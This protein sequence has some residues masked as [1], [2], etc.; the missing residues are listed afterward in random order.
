MSRR[1]G[2][3]RDLAAHLV[4][5]ELVV[6]PVRHHSPACAAQVERVVR[7]RRPSVVL[8]EGPRGFDPLVPLLARPD[9]VMPLAVYTWLDARATD[10]RVAAYYPFCDYSPELVAIRE[11]TAAGTPVRFIDLELGEQQHSAGT[12]PPESL[13]QET[14]YRHSEGLRLLAERLGCRDHEDLWERLFESRSVPLEEYVAQVAAYCLLARDDHTPE[15]LAADGTLAREAEM[16]HHV[17]EALAARLPGDGPV[18]VVLG[19][20]HAVALPDLLATPPSRPEL[21]APPAQSALIRYTF[22]RLEQLNGYA[23]GMTS[24]AWHQLLWEHRDRAGGEHPRVQATLLALQRVVAELRGPL[25]MPVPHPL[26]AAA[27]AHA[28]QLAHLRDREAP[29]RSDLLDAITSC[30]VQGDVDVEGRIVLTAAH[31]VLTGDRIG[32]VPAGAGRPPLVVDTLRR[33]RAQRLR[34][35]ELDRSSVA[36]DLYRREAHRTTSRLLHGLGLL[37]IPFAFRAAGPDFVS[38]TGLGRL[39]ERWDYQWSPATEGALAEASVLGSTLPEAVARRF[40]QL[41]A[42]FEEAAA[43]S[44]PAA[45]GLLTQ[46][47]TVGLHDRLDQVVRLVREAVTADAAFDGVVTAVS[48]LA[49]LAEAREPLGARE[50]AELPAL[51]QL[52]YARAIYLGRG[53]EAAAGGPRDVAEGLARLRELLVSEAGVALDPDLYWAMLEGLRVDHE[54]SLVRGAAT[55]LLHAAGRLSASDLAAAVGGNLR[56]T[57]GAADAVGFLTGLLMTAREAAWQEP[58]VLG[59]LDERFR[60]WDHQTFVQHLPDLRLAFASLTPLETDRV[61][62]AVSDLHGIGGGL[63][64]PVR[65]DVDED[66]V[67][68][69]LAVDGEVAALLDRDGL[70]PWRSER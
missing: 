26:V 11:A 30:L 70:T 61:A 4:T 36:L 57:V 27:Y 16:V 66:D 23:A 53:M 40:D 19:G 31:R 6:V 45:V 49:L 1:T 68:A 9:A 18:L 14:H 28:V 20:F 44:A 10:E 42:A 63:D 58:E 47:C 12:S 67:Q 59:G 21:A 56:G 29:L 32:V 17:R 46:A 54:G 50:L 65:R 15:L 5:A 7:D 13:A 39:Q 34:V 33:L 41:V 25:E 48:S 69:L 38:G 22:E 60:S 64:A 51:L 52:A 55:G 24:P 37:G 43:P 35:D 8:I 62:T 2:E 3:V